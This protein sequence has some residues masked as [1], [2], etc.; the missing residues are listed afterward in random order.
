MGDANNGLNE[1]A[2]MQLLAERIGIQFADLDTIEVAPNV[3]RMLS[4]KLARHYKVVPLYIDGR[5]LHVAVSDAMNFQA[6]DD[7]KISTRMNIVP[8][9][10]MPKSIDL[11]LNKYYRSSEQAEQALQEF[12]EI[13]Q[14]NNQ[15]ANIDEILMDVD[16][17]PIVRMVN[18]ILIDAVKAQASDIHIEPYEHDIRVR[19]RVD[20]DLVEYLKMPP[21]TLS[22][23]VNRIKILSKLNITE[24]KRPQDGRMQMKYNGRKI[25][26]RVSMLP[27]VYG[28]KTVIRLLNA[29]EHILTVKELGF[30][31][32]NQQ[33]VN[34][35]MKISEGMI[36]L[37]GPTGSGKTTTLY[38]LLQEMNS[39]KKNVIT[40]EDPVEMQLEGVNQ[41][42]VNAQIGMTFA[43]GL[44]SILRQDP[45]IIMLGEIRDEETAEIAIRSS[46]TGHVVLSTLH[47]N[48]TA[49]SITRLTD[50]GIPSYMITNAVA[51]IVAQR[52]LKKNCPQCSKPYPATEEEKKIL[53]IEGEDVVLHRGTGC[54]YCSN[55]GYKGRTSIHEILVFDKD[56]KAMINDHES[57]ERIKQRACEKGMQ[58]LAMSAKE[59]VLSGATTVE[60]LVRATYN[61]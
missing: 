39:P 53:G 20:G 6:M 58:T 23:V 12:E 7:L 42:P 43:S 14:Q 56:I 32:Y 24:T 17:A 2:Y 51:G 4:E 15:S 38:A 13:E 27:T 25:N 33:Q 49:S 59:L 8:M 37:T 40:L 48:D 54:P 30:T 18:S 1:K 41:V 11:A 3:I 55:S 19:Y 36:L 50:M 21:S 35:M 57:A 16:S 52:L 46:V 10:A 34:R 22:G 29:M 44:R 61:L 26:M 28:E 47:T 31:A 9:L 5:N 45:D 60:Q